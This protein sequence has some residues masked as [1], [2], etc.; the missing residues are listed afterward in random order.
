MFF[1]INK[2]K[3]ESYVISIATVIV[4]FIMAGS[5]NTNGN[6]IETAANIQNEIT[7]TNSQNKSI[8][9]NTSNTENVSNI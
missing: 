3:L 7:N 1:I 9:N 4:L 5:I 2:E 6:V 8:N